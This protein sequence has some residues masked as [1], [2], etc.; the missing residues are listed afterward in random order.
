MRSVAVAARKLP[1]TK[2]PRFTPPTAAERIAAGDLLLR[3]KDYPRAIDELNK[4]VELGRQGKVS[5]ASL[6]DGTYLLAEAYFRSEQFLSA[7]RYY[8][9]IIDKAPA[10]P[11]DGYAGRALSRLVD[12]ALRTD[13]LESLDYVFARIDSLGTS[14]ASGSLQY[15][16]G[17][18][19]FARGDFSGAKAAVN[20]LPGAVLAGGHHHEGS[21][22]SR[23]AAAR[24][25][26]YQG[27]DSGSSRALCGS[28]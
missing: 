3:T 8:R 21:G 5:A 10:P 1:T 13:S 16:R 15:A 6:V 7:R 11:Y 25:G 9:Q 22:S 26:R 2:Q 12:I 17:K 19:F 4:V 18:A 24:G 28:D 20:S 14:D 23:G 27:T